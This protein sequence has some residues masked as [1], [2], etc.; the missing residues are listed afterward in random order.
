MCKRDD[1]IQSCQSSDVLLSLNFCYQCDW[2]SGS[3]KLN[4]IQS[5][6]N[7]QTQ[8]IFAQTFHS[9]IRGANETNVY[10]CIDMMSFCNDSTWLLRSIL[11]S[12]TRSLSARWLFLFDLSRT[13]LLFGWFSLVC[14]EHS[15]CYYG[16]KHQYNDDIL[17]RLF[18]CSFVRPFT[19]SY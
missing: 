10:A 7:T 9:T 13:V 5:N 8:Q 4:A 6:K 18:V 1:Y 11:F 12:G 2:S 17:F 14:F 3:R 15:I 16:N 19:C